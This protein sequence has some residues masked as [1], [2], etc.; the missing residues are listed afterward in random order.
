MYAAV[1]KC[2]S[3]GGFG[4]PWEG[5]NHRLK[6]ELAEEGERP[7]LI[8]SFADRHAIVQMHMCKL[9]HAPK[10]PICLSDQ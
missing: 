5:N 6:A 1:F 7:Q 4:G 10:F 8:T 9:R 3:L 2:T